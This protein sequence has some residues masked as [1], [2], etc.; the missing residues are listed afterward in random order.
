LTPDSCSYLVS[1]RNVWFSHSLLRNPRDAP[2]L[3]QRL[4]RPRRLHR[5]H[6]RALPTE[7]L[8]HPRR[9]R[10]GARVVTAVKHRSHFGDERRVARSFQ[11]VPYAIPRRCVAAYFPEANVLVPVGSVAERSNT[12]TSKSIHVSLAP[13]I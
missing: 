1:I 7:L 13:A 2:Q 5:P 10:L 12:P 4:D 9:G 6:L 3:R 11:L 8:D